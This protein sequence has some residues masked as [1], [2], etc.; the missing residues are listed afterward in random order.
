MNRENIDFR[1]ASRFD[2]E[3][4]VQI[5]NQ[6]ILKKNLTAY[7]RP[8]SVQDR[9]TWFE[10]HKS[11]N[12]PIFIAESDNQI[13][14]WISLSPYRG[15]REGLLKTVEVSYFVDNDF[16]QRGVGSKMLKKILERAKNLEYE[17]V[18][19]IIFETN[20]GS[21]K[22]LQKNGFERWGLLPDVAQI[23]GK[24]FSHGYYGLKL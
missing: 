23:D 16:Q 19:A 21:K 20:L 13:V 11:D 10:E 15:G 22:L 1:I 12:Y 3:R 5:T 18:V 8:L 7:I 4:I 6:A 2:L 9:C 17:T 24:T 14:G